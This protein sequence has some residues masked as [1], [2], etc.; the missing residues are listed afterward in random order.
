MS[1]GVVVQTLR[2]DFSST[3]VTTSAYVELAAALNEE[4][5]GAE[6]FNSS[7]ETLIAAIGAASSEQDSFYILP[8]GNDRGALKIPKG[9]RLAIKAVSANATSGELT[10]NFFG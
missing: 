6:I 10:I 8:G 2:H 9:A 1:R 5:A 3:N 4:V 7:G